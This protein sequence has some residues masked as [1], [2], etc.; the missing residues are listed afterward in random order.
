MVFSIPRTLDQINFGGWNI[1][2]ND[3]NFHVFKSSS[4]NWRIDAAGFKIG[5]IPITIE[6]LRSLVIIIAT[7]PDTRT[8]P[9]QPKIQGRTLKLRAGPMYHA[10]STVSH[11]SQV[12]S[13]SFSVAGMPADT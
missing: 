7:R 1:S 11:P 8:N 6:S 10:M 13:Q 12:Q 4:S 5:F 9:H 3:E 2:E